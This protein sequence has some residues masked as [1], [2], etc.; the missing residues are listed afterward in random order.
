[1]GLLRKQQCDSHR[2]SQGKGFHG[3][4]ELV[5]LVVTLLYLRS[6]VSVTCLASYTK[7]WQER[8]RLLDA[9][10][11]SF[12]SYNSL[13]CPKRQVT[14][15]CLHHIYCSGLCRR[16]FSHS[17]SLSTSRRHK[18]HLPWKKTHTVGGILTV[19]TIRDIQHLSQITQSNIATIYENRVWAWYFAHYYFCLT[20][21]LG[22]AVGGRQTVINCGFVKCIVL[23]NLNKRERRIPD[24][25]TGNAAISVVC[26]FRRTRYEYITVHTW[27]KRQEEGTPP[28]VF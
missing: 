22:F 17:S 27:G 5:D 9:W 18:Q 26:G 10:R 2:V 8:V 23:C 28:L 21:A 15:P 20:F 4:F 11:H 13:L 19:E 12:L 24:N 6:W 7:R 16:M 14:A 25:T 3:S 1:M